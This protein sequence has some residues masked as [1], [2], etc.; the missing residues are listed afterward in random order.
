MASLALEIPRT[1]PLSSPPTPHL[2]PL[3]PAGQE[4][5]QAP[6]EWGWIPALL[7]SP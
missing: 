7:A 2:W 5:S 6:W 3:T 4:S 1:R